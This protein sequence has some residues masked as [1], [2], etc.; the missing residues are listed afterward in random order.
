MAAKRTHARDPAS[1]ELTPLASRVVT[2]LNLLWEGRQRRMAADLDISPAAI[3]R[4][5]RG[6]QAVGPRVLATIASHPRVNGTWLRTGIGEPQLVTAPE[7][8]VDDWLAPIANVILP[9]LPAENEGLLGGVRLAV[10]GAY[11][12]P[13]RYVLVVGAD[14][15]IVRADGV[16]VAAGDRLLLDS[17]PEVWRGN[18]QVLAGRI[19]AVRVRRPYRMGCV[20]AGRGHAR[21]R[22]PRCE[23]QC[24]RGPGWA[25]P[26][27]RSGIRAPPRPASRVG[28]G[29]VIRTGI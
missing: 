3:S 11:R 19:V 23:H 21:P 7:R 26:G 15:P 1:P 20:R 29:T 24:L 25:H 10:A 14:D 8:P 5:V 9:G 18:Q 6:E 13:S 2:V 22:G 27:L 17:D 28:A 4:I 16:K 12:R